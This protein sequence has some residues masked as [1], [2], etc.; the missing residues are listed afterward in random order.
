MESST[1]VSG[2]EVRALSSVQET[3][4]QPNRNFLTSLDFV[5]TVAVLL[6]VLDHTLLVLHHSLGGRSAFIGLVGVWMFFV[7]TTLVLMWSLERKPY[8]LDF[9]IRRAFRIY[10]LAILAILVAVL[11]HAPVMGGDSLHMFQY[12]PASLG[13]IVASISLLGNLAP[14]FLNYHELVYVVWTLPLEVEM[15]IFL[16]VLFAFARRELR[17]WPL[18]LMWV[19]VFFLGN[20]WFSSEV[21]LLTAA[22]AFLPGVIAFVAYKRFQPR[23]PSWLFPIA[24]GVLLAIMFV[25]HRVWLGGAFALTLGLLLPCFRSFPKSFFTT[26]CHHVAKYSYGIYLSHPFALV[27]GMYLLRGHSLALQ[28]SIEIATIAIVSVAGYHLLE[29][30]MIDLGS[31]IAARAEISALARHAG[32]ARNSL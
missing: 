23:L 8:T 13:N 6:V 15:Y 14:K 26:I 1:D 28:L 11:T 22:S 31:R 25:L 3:L 9:Y 10:P 30:P 4:V 19:L 21:N 16:P 12:I 17:I 24:L 2:K 20:H 32:T 29:K 5:R 7:H 27:L 18:L